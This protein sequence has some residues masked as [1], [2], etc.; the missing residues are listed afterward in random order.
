LR[1]EPVRE[2]AVGLEE[3]QWMVSAAAHWAL[4]NG[5]RGRSPQVPVKDKQLSLTSP[6]FR[7]FVEYQRLE[8]AIGSEVLPE[9]VLPH[10]LEKLS[11]Q[12]LQVHLKIL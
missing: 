9:Q 8:Y 7:G 1:Q 2:H 11:E 5:S 4:F 3:K 12:L 6:I 10:F